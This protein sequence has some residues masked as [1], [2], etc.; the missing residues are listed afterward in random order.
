MNFMKNI[1]ILRT[2]FTEQE[3]KKNLKKAQHKLQK[4]LKEKDCRMAAFYSLDAAHIYDLLAEREKAEYYYRTTLKY[5]DHAKF[6]PLWIRIECLSALGRHE[7]ALHTILDDPHPPQ[8]E[9]ARLYENMGNHDIARKV[10]TELAVEQSR[11]ADESE[12]LQPLFL[13]HASDLWEKAQNIEKAHKYRERALEAWEKMKNMQLSLHTI[14]EAWL[15]EEVGYIYEKAGKFKTAHKY[16]KKAESKYE[17]A[18][19]VDVDSAEANYADGD[20]DYYI[21]CFNFQLPEIRMIELSFEYFIRFDFKRIRYRNLM[22][23]KKMK[24]QENST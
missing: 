3:L 18:Y 17:R 9:L 4:E 14:E 10:Y 20:W 23:E 24:V 5:L 15:Y 8:L 1:E 13:Q 22:L 12:F 16:Y 7:E 2:L 19:T 6:Q 11:K 21:G